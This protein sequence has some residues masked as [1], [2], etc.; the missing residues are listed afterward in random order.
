MLLKVYDEI[1]TS[2]YVH[3][4]EFLYPEELVKFKDSHIKKKK[5]DKSRLEKAAEEFKVDYGEITCAALYAE[6]DFAE[7]LMANKDAETAFIKKGIVVRNVLELAYLAVKKSL[8][9]TRAAKK[10][11]KDISQVY[12]PTDRVIQK[13][14]Q[15]GFG[16]LI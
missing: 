8:Y 9:D 12:K 10:L 16:F 2:D 5:P 13:F 1:W 4:K 7:L 14:K 6:G 11:I 3:E 15:E